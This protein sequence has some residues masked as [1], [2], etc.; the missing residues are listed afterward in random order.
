MSDHERASRLY[1]AKIC[2][3]PETDWEIVHKI[4]PST[5]Y[6]FADVESRTHGQCWQDERGVWKQAP[7]GANPVI[8]ATRYVRAGGLDQ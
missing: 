7:R 3:R 4:E 6:D 1:Y 5:F 2:Q 8:L